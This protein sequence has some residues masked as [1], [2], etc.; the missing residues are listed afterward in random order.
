MQSYNKHKSKHK[1]GSNDDSEMVSKFSLSSPVKLD[2][3]C[4][5][6]LAVVGRGSEIQLQV[7]K[8]MNGIALFSFFLRVNNCH[9]LNK[10]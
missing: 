6:P 8:T 1:V 5:H 7:G 10:I 2:I 3:I 9:C 4:F